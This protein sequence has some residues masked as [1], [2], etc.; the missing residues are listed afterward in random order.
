MHHL[1]LLLY[2]WEDQFKLCDM[3]C[4]II[5]GFSLTGCS[6]VYKLHL[7]PPETK[8]ICP[9]HTLLP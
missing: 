1:Q 6:H 4:D 9:Q 8:I 3:P 2:V 5:R 7:F